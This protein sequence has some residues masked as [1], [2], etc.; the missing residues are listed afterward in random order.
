MSTR[1]REPQWLELPVI[2][3]IQEELVA[4]FG[5]LAGVRDQ[6]LLESA[7]NKPRHLLHYGEPDLFDLAAAY[8]HGIANNHPFCD[9]NKRAAFMAAYTFLEANGQHFNAE[10]TQ[11]VIMTLGLA[12]KSVS[13][14]RYAAWL[15]ENCQ[16]A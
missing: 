14:S 6:G 13:Q 9:G 12:D 1:K 16:A 3:A 2:L 15:R 10:E 7:L 8:A 11:V 5:G 4:E